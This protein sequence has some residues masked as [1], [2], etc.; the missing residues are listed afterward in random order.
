MK[1]F[2]KESR[3]LMNKGRAILE[4]GHSHVEGIG[5]RYE[6]ESVGVKRKMDAIVSKASDK[7]DGEVI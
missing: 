2:L 4:A 1:R 6:R 3:V 7:D 5:Q